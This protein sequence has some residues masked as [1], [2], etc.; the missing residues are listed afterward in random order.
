[1]S[2]GAGVPPGVPKADGTQETVGSNENADADGAGG[3]LGDPIDFVAT[4]DGL[5]LGWTL[6]SELKGSGRADVAGYEL[7]NLVGSAD[8]PLDVVR[9]G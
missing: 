2:L 8:W 7:G 4:L 6:A 9:C 3:V 1:M 5:A